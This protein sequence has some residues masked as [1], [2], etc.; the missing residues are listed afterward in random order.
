MAPEAQ[1]AEALGKGFS[2]QFSASPLGQEWECRGRV[3]VACF[4]G[5]NQ[6]CTRDAT[7]A[8]S[9]ITRAAISHTPKGKSIRSTWQKEASPS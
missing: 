7:S 3:G 2:H 1:T 8:S 5:S 4:L 6:D 9:T